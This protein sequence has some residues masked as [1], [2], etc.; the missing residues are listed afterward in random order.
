MLVTVDYINDAG[1]LTQTQVSYPVV[2]KSL[3]NI[4]DGKMKLDGIYKTYYFMIPFL[5]E[6]LTN[7]SGTTIFNEGD[8]YY[9][10]YIDD[11]GVIVKEY[12][13]LNNNI[14]II[15]DSTSTITVITATYPLSTST[16]YDLSDPA[17]LLAFIDTHTTAVEGIDFLKN[18]GTFKNIKR[19]DSYTLFEGAFG[20]DAHLVTYD[21][22]DEIIDSI[23][24]C[25]YPCEK[26]ST[27]KWAGLMQKKMAA[28]VA[29]CNNNLQQ[30]AR[31]MGTVEKRCKGCD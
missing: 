5:T 9:F 11:N 26:F 4:Y 31:I 3:I 16:I 1:F 19:A 7:H 27:D 17:R 14:T 15:Y 2:A 23:T 8:I 13:V 12:R 10:E 6:I 24:D 25:E 20:E 30:A 28:S 21:L 29:F 22:R 18:L